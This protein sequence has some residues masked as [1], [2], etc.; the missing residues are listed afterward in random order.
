MR[1]L[2]GKRV[3]ALLTALAVLMALTACGTEKE[4]GDALE[5]PSQ[6]EDTV[7]EGNTE[8][9]EETDQEEPEETEKAEEE[10]P[11]EENAQEDDKE[12]AAQPSVPEEAG[13][14]LSRTDFTL[15]AA[16]SSYRLTVTGTDEACTYT[17][18]DPQVAT[19]SEDGT[20]TAVAPGKAVVTVTAGEET[21]TCVVRCRWTD[22]EEEPAEESVDL[23]AF[24]QDTIT[25]HTFQ[26]LQEFTGEVLD[27]YYPGMNDIATK[28]CLIMGTMMSMNNGEFCLVEVSDSAD[29]DAVKEILQSRIDYMAESGAWYPGPTELWTNSSRVVSHG[30]YVMMVVHEQ[31]DQIVDEFEALFA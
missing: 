16:G 13:M 20:V 17:S 18:S 23:A 29:V 2:C 6:A 26:T 14:T 24:Y 10:T 30:N 21:R 19:V 8:Q 3:A 5:E 25:N 9:T 11:E 7:P 1:K 12:D 4:N 27:T 15:F 22:E 28:Q 31:C